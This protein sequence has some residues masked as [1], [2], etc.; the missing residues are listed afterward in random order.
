MA[1][2]EAQ[3]ELGAK[4]L[5]QFLSPLL[6]D[7][8]RS[9]RRVGAT[10]YVEGLLMPG[11][12][13]SIGPMAERLGVDS[14][15]LQHFITDSPWEE[16]AI[17]KAL[18]PLAVDSVEPLEAWIVDETGWLKQGAHS[19]GVAHQYCGA[20][21]K[22]ANCQVNVQVAITDGLVAVPVGA[23]L[24][25][26]ESWTKDPARCR[27]AGVPEEVE[28]ETKPQI[29][30]SL[31][32]DLLAEG[33][34]RAPVLGDNAYGINGEFRDGLRALGLEFFLQ[35]DP[36]QLLGWAQPV[37]LEKKRTRWH[38]APKVPAAPTLLKLWATQPAVKWRACSWKAAEGQTRHTRLGWMRV[39]LPGVLDRG[40]QTLE[41]VWL[42]VDW[43]E[44]APEAY[45]YY[46]AH[47]HRE[48]TVARCLRL[49]R[50]RWNI[51]QYFQR[52]KDDLGLDHFE[53]RS[54]RGFHHHLVM[55]VLAYLFVVG[56]YLDA[57]KNFWCDVGA[58]AEEDASVAGEVSRL[59]LLLRQKV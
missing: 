22:S 51:E 16:A 41:E 59:L 34:V 1:W 44:G 8:G 50:S 19:V 13:K 42:V 53:G 17:W 9:E 21:G 14:Q 27:E 45:H 32:K 3:W 54:W 36:G 43:P 38:V 10:L 12:R 48:P 56:V 49:S 31:I 25:L 26:P 23:R 28:F 33:V 4:R 11:Q 20:V 6:Q 18:R 40:A 24:Y 29:A 55:A 47:L 52:A 46:L 30:L 58:G 15:K 7:L 35:I 39:Y 5:P 2:N 57:K 37:G